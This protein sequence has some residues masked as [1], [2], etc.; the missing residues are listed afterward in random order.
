MLQDKHN[1][2]KCLPFIF[3]ILPFAPPS[4]AKYKTSKYVNGF[5]FSF[6]KDKWMDVSKADRMAV[7]IEAEGPPETS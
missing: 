2:N 7:I 3:K 1:K 4:V 6:E 5:F